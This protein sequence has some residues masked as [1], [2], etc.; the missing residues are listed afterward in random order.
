MT[1]RET[2]T[3]ELEYVVEHTHACST[4]W[5][6]RKLNAGLIPGR[7]AGRH[8]YM[9]ESDIAALVDFMARPARI[10]IPAETTSCAP[11]APASRPRLTARARANLQRTA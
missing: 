6:K 3:Y 8:W 1:D 10:H 7:K 11:D 5:L 9:T 4:N 2:K